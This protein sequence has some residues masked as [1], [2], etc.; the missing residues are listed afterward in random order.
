MISCRVSVCKPSHAINV[1][2][3][4]GDL[5]QCSNVMHVALSDPHNQPTLLNGHY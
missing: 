2:P 3:L 5:K 1:S 4:Q